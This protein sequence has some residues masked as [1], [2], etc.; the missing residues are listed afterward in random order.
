M[1]DEPRVL[2]EY[3]CEPID[4]KEFDRQYLAIPPGWTDRQQEE[5]AAM[6]A[7]LVALTA[8]RD[9]ALLALRAFRDGI[10]LYQAAGQLAQRAD[11]A[12]VARQRAESAEAARLAWQD[13]AQRAEAEVVRLRRLVA[14]VAR[15]G[16]VL[17][18]D[19]QDIDTEVCGLCRSWGDHASDCLLLQCR[20]EAAR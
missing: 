2:P 18:R 8:E 4:P 9:A 14:A 17:S 12:T 3:L 19:L 10:S 11:E 13:Q 16:P 1:S 15:T 20:A 5:T 7:Q 6:R